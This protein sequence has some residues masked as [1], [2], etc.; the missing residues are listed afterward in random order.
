MKIK[1]RF[2]EAI[3]ASAFEVLQRMR[4]QSVLAERTRVDAYYQLGAD[5]QRSTRFEQ[6]LKILDAT[7]QQVP[8]YSSLNQGAALCDFPVL[9]KSILR[10]ERDRLTSNLANQDELIRVTTSGSSGEPFEW[11]HDAGK[12]RRKLADLLYFNTV[13]GYR[14]GMKHA[15]IRATS[16]GKLIQWAQNQV[17][18]DPTQCDE[19]FKAGL[20]EQL[21]NNSIRV[22]I[23]YPS[24][25]AD[26][27]E[28]CKRKGD[29]SS[30]FPLSLYVVTSEIVTEDQRDL[31]REVFDCTIVS[32]Y[33]T[34]EFGILAQSDERCQEFAINTGSV[35]VEILKLDSDL[36]AQAGEVGRVVVTDLYQQAMPLIRYDIGDLAVA[37]EDSCPDLGVSH[38]HSLEGKTAHMITNQ[39]GKSVAPLSILVAFKDFEG[40]QEF[41]FAQLGHG[42]YQLR[43]CPEDAVIQA[44]VSSRLE[45][46]LGVGAEIEIKAMPFIP[47]QISGKRP[48]VVNEMAEPPAKLCS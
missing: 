40:V 2:S 30:D 1:L 25:M 18:V 17:W 26:V 3:R 37:N 10:S 45:N 19:P 20:R 27:A 5:E 41:Q 11:F 46:I 36:P 14:L 35:I 48:V 24:V 15:L 47:K 22:V 8:Y 28:Y 33:A 31:I 7:I 34:E 38:L 43:V 42:R 44:K 29:S 6:S 23:G 16:K 4:G 12:R 39:D 32:R 9:N 21:L 13:A